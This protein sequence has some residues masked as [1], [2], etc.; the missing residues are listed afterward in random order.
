VGQWSQNVLRLRWN[1]ARTALD[2]RTPEMMAVLISLL[3]IILKLHWHASDVLLMP[4]KQRIHHKMGKSSLETG[5]IA[6]G[7]FTGHRSLQLAARIRLPTA[8][9]TMPTYTVRWWLGSRVVSVLDSGAE[10]PGFKSQSRRCRVTVLGKLFTPTVPL[11]TKQ[12]NW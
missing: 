4:P 3:K 8:V 6:G 1:F 7:F 11:F 2:A 9:Y 5:R 10:R 12:Q